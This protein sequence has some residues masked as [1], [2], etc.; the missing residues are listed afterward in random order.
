MSTQD[1][2]LLVPISQ[3]DFLKLNSGFLA[4][5]KYLFSRLTGCWH[6]K[7]TRP[8]THGRRTYRVC[9]RCGMQRNF[10]L[11]TWKSKG[12]FYAPSIDES[13]RT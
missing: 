12:R 2:R 8:F 9:V 7:L 6:R 5:L 3:S 11:K 1:T 4:S 10:D 13:A